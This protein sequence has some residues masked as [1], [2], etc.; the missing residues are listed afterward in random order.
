MGRIFTHPNLDLIQLY[1]YLNLRPG[2]K[3]P[4]ISRNARPCAPAAAIRIC[5]TAPT[6]RRCSRAS[7]RFSAASINPHFAQYRHSASLA[8]RN[9][10]GRCASSVR[11]FLELLLLDGLAEFA[12]PQ[13]LYFR[14]PVISESHR[15]GTSAPFGCEAH[16]M[17]HP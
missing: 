1:R 5:P 14:V 11:F 10:R 17:R 9:S 13:V 8:M 6:S 15:F 4:L 7:R 2:V 3:E 12:T 16:L